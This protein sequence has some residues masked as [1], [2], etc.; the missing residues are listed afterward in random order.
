MST[1]IVPETVQPQLL[2]DEINVIMKR[3][4]LACREIP[5]CLQDLNEDYFPHGDRC[6][7]LQEDIRLRDRWVHGMFYEFVSVKI[8]LPLK[9]STPTYFFYL[10]RC[11]FRASGK[12]YLHLHPIQLPNVLDVL[13]ILVSNKNPCHPRI[14]Q[15]AE[16]CRRDLLLTR[17]L[18]IREIDM[19]WKDL[20]NASFP[21]LSVSIQKPDLDVPNLIFTPR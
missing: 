14:D 19:W 15:V 3:I 10:K 1:Q 17:D 11:L 7:K 8:L 21:V 9:S 6:S 18:P 20:S 4:V 13:L 16:I 5:E 2:E 12:A